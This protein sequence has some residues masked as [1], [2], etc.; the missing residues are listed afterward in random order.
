MDCDYEDK[1][2][3]KYGA[4]EQDFDDL[5]A[6]AAEVANLLQQAKEN[7]LRLQAEIKFL[8]KRA[9]MLRGSMRLQEPY[10]TRDAVGDGGHYMLGSSRAPAGRMVLDGDFYAKALNSQSVNRF[11]SRGPSST[12]PSLKNQDVVGVLKTSSSKQVPNGVAPT[13]RSGKR[14][15]SWQD[16]FSV[17]A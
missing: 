7:K 3:L 13:K 2:V 6:E 11:S 15:I 14:K 16:E 10:L 17:Q 1:Y 5:E 8:K 4:L 9:M 12:R